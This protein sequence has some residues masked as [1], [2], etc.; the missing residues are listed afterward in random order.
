MTAYH[1]HPVQHGLHTYR[2]ACGY[3]MSH[4]VDNHAL[5]G[6]LLDVSE[7]SHLNERIIPTITSIAEI[8]DAVVREKLEVLIKEPHVLG[9]MLWGS[10]ATGFRDP[11]TD[12]DAL[13]YTTEEYYDSLELKDTIWLEFDESVEPRRLV[14]DF[15]PVADSWFRQQLESPLDIDHF[16]YVEGVVIHDPTGN[17]EEWR[18]RLARYPEEEH[19]DRLKNKYILLLGSLGYADINKRRGFVIDSQL[20][21]YRA[22]VAAVNLWFTMKKS[23]TPPLKWWSRHAQKMG[24]SEETFDLFS[25]CINTPSYENL[26]GLFK[27]LRQELLESGFTF[28]N[29]SMSTFLETIHV[30]GR[31]AQIRHSYL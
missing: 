9:V 13:I 18:R 12:W 14:I 24:M 21:V 8:D 1:S 23:W 6:I 16:P 31:A 4:R 2:C 7:A 10:R 27:H 5:I 17:L 28:P 29:D 19:L 3:G 22:I 26:V 25:R 30:R 20:N 11:S 15:S